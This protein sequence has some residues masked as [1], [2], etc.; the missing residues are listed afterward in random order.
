MP[1]STTGVAP[2]TVSTETAENC[3]V[4]VPGANLELHEN[5]IKS[6][7]LSGAKIVVCQNEISLE[8]T[9][10]TLK[11]AKSI[12]LTTV[13]GMNF[14]SYFVSDSNDFFLEKSIQKMPLSTFS[15][16]DK[17]EKSERIRNNIFK[18]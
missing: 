12:G 3:I 11:L 10:H 8:T 7:D 17:K 13:R 6:E 1:D 9:A 14:S 5:D 18:V 4:V 15:R 16:F 2:I